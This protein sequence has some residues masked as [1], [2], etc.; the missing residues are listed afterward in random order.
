VLAQALRFDFPATQL[1]M[2]SGNRDKAE[3]T[4]KDLKGRVKE[5][6]GALTRDARLKREG[7]ADQAEGRGQKAVGKVKKKLGL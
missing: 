4:G 7:R 2:K 6:A 1:T 3:G 5:G